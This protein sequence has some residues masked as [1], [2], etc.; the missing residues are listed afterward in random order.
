[1]VG[2]LTPFIFQWKMLHF[3]SETL[4]FIDAIRVFMSLL[5]YPFDVHKIVAF[6]LLH[7]FD[8]RFHFD[9]CM[10]SRCSIYSKAFGFKY[11]LSKLLV[12]F[13]PSFC[14]N[15]SCCSHVKSCSSKSNTAVAAAFWKYGKVLQ[16]LMV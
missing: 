8:I 15:C 4:T 14:Y 6:P 5:L 9:P 3:V 10:T 7:F 12:Y 2:P 16:F 11:G 1:M 13:F